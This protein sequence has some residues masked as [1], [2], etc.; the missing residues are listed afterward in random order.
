MGDAICKVSL[1]DQRQLLNVRQQ[2]VYNKLDSYQIGRVNVYFKANTIL[3]STTLYSSYAIDV[4]RIVYG[5]GELVAQ[6]PNSS[7]LDSV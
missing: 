4:M 6:L 1:K 2:F 5:E 7:P 3:D